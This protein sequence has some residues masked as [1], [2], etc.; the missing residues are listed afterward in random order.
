MKKWFTITQD[1]IQRGRSGDCEN[2]PIALAI[3]EQMGWPYGFVHVNTCTVSISSND[4]TYMPSEA[5]AFVQ[6]FD[7]GLPVYPQSIL[8]EIP[9]ELV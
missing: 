6:E 9:E 3:I 1:H 7:I 2:C 8:L 5:Q 4:Y